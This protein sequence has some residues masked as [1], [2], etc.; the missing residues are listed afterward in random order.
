MQNYHTIIIQ[1]SYNNQL[2][3]RKEDK[4]YA[5]LI[6]HFVIYCIMVDIDFVF[7]PGAIWIVMQRNGGRHQG[8]HK[9]K[10]DQYFICPYSNT[11]QS[12]IMVVRK[13]EVINK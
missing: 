13:K 9:P 12:N 6:D 2:C 11:A 10:S 1:L 4:I 3:I 5:G 7:M 8:I